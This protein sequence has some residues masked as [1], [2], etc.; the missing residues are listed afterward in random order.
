MPG[1]RLLANAKAL[2][3][4]G[5]YLPRTPGL[6]QTA[7]ALAESPAELARQLAGLPAG[8][9]LVVLSHATPSEV[10]AVRALLAARCGPAPAE[11]SAP[12][13]VAVRAV[14]PGAAT[15]NPLAQAGFRLNG[16]RSPV[17][18]DAPA[19]AEPPE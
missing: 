13:V 5:Y 4:L 1:E 9:V 11:A 15:A 10:A 3:A 12:G 16:A 8:P 7:T 18:L 17:T 6:P 14:L 2:P 19:P